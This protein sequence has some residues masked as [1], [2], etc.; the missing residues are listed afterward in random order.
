MIFL[1]EYDR[2]QGKL[3]EIQPFPDYDRKYAQRQRLKRE[4]ELA[5][6]GVVR[7]VVLLEAEDRKALERTHQRYFKTATELL[8]SEVGEYPK[9]PENHYE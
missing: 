3:L 8:E 9:L 7:D 5:L 4:L 2:R 1:I 6:S